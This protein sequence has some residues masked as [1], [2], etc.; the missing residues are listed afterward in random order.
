MTLD[1]MI[2]LAVLC[3]A[4]LCFVFGKWR[5]D[6]VSLLALLA[7]AVAGVVPVQEVFEGFGHPAVIT[8]GAVLVVSR[9]LQNSGVVDVIA[10]WMLRVGDN[11]SVQ[12]AAMTGLVGVLS[13]FMNNVGALALL[14]PVAIQLARKSALPLHS[15]LMPLAFGSLL[16]G[17]TTLIGT[18]PNLI[19]STFRAQTGTGPFQMFDFLPV[20]LAALLAGWFFISL[21][22]W[23]LIPQRAGQASREELF[24]VGEYLTEARVPEDSNMIGKQLRDFEAI[25]EADA[26]VVGLVRGGERIL[27][28]SS[29]E[30]L[31]AND[32]LLIEADP[33][34]LKALLDATKLELVGSKTMSAEALGSENVGVIEY[35]VMPN[36]PMEGRTAWGLNLRWRHGVNL[37]GVARQGH[38]LNRRLGRIEFRIGD[39]LLLQGRTEDLQE[40]L[41]MLGCLPLLE[42][43]LRFGQPRRILLSVILFGSAIVATALNLLPVQIAFV[44][45]AVAM[46]LF[47]LLSLSEAYESID[48]PILVLLGTMIPVGH[49]LESTGAAELITSTLLKGAN[50]ESAVWIL[51]VLMVG[52]MLLS[53]VLN[54]AATAIL[55]APIALSTAQ[56]IGAAVEPFLMSVAVGASCAFLTPIGHQSNTLVMGPGGYQFGDYWRMGLALSIVVGATSIPVILWFWPLELQGH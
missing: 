26:T 30:A 10:R 40:T 25:V 48:W 36:S 54:N 55:M 13:G 44:A 43:G 20:G 49:A 28:P 21:I 23:R 34:T 31:H 42:R 18:P 4:L 53:N 14:L 19:I 32:I 1:Q 11:P 29:Y 51:G 56:E 37:L 35:V 16:G 22:G 6:V 9:G 38:R 24:H 39:V 15:L 17:M 41:S 33:E 2:V 50:L 46:V 3:A 45:A 47:N 27:V 7:V 8:V 5:Y 52:T 12:V